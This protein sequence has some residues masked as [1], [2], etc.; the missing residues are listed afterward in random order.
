PHGPGVVVD[1]SPTV[2]INGLPACRQGDTII[3][4]IGP[5]DKILLGM[6]TVIIGNVPE[7]GPGG[8]GGGG[9]AG[10]AAAKSDG[11]GATGGSAPTDPEKAKAKTIADA[12]AKIEASDFGKTDAGKK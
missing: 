8:G 1:G 4:A 6:Q 5:P 12:I 7:A 10:P 3:E 9:G 11:A 2:L